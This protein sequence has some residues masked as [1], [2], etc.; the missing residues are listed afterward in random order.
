MK[1]LYPAMAHVIAI[2]V[3]PTMAAPRAVLAKAAATK[4]PMLHF[5]SHHATTCSDLTS[6]AGGSSCR[7]RLTASRQRGWKR[8]P[9]GTRA[10]LWNLAPRSA[11]M[12]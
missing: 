6:M 7:Q 11:G 4:P 8:Q 12:V 5:A 9:S 3:P 10:A 1:T 2:F